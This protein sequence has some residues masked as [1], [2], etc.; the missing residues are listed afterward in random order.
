MK[1]CENVIASLRD[2]K[3]ISHLHHLE[4]KG[5]AEERRAKSER[6]KERKC[7]NTEERG[8]GDP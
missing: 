1:Y 6:V 5:G 8:G 4:R 7:E 2:R 3:C